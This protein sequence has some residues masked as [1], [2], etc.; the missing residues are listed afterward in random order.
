MLKKFFII[1]MLIFTIMCHA[2]E[3]AFLAGDDDIIVEEPVIEEEEIIEEEE[4]IE[5]PQFNVWLTITRRPVM[6]VGEPVYIYVHLEGFDN[7]E[8]LIVWRCDHKDGNGFQLIE[9][10]NEMYYM[11]SASAETLSWDWEVTVYYR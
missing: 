4:V 7:Y 2:E 11:F 5:E 9:G 8:T 6:E 1:F 3:T 10:W